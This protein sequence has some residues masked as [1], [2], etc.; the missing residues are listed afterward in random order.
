MDLF[1][2]MEKRRSVRRFDPAREV[3]PELVEEL[4]RCACLAPSAGNVQP[5][6]F[7]VVRDPR[8]KEE[9]ARAALGQGFVARAPVVI[10]I[11]ADLNAH[12]AAYGKRGVELYSIQDTAAAAENLLLAATSLGLGACWIGAFQE[13]EAASALGLERGLR[14]LALIP[15]GYPAAPASPPRKLDHRRLTRYL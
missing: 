13:E 2:A 7:L 12:A 6:R 1:E 10:V 8:L 3:P 9:L 11:C 5:W 4:L 14:P 15:L